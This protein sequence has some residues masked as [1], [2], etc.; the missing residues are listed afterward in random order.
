MSLKC[1][2][3]IMSQTQLMRC[4]SVKY[5]RNTDDT[6]KRVCWSMIWST[7]ERKNGAMFVEKQFETPDKVNYHGCVLSCLLTLR[8]IFSS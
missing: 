5:L 1:N 3:V 8:G 6:R 7:R 2:Y 4:F